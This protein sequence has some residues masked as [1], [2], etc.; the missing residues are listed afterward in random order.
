M[1]EMNSQQINIVF[2]GEALV[3]EKDITVMDLL[4]LLEVVTH[5][6]VVVINN[7]IVPKS[8]YEA[9]RLELGDHCDIMSPISGG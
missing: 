7:Q 6:F 3:V 8:A 1:S 5:R 2:N 4:Q 9:I